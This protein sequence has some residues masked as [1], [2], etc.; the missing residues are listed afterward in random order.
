MEARERLDRFAMLRFG[1]REERRERGMP[2]A[3]GSA[4]HSWRKQ[5]KQRNSP[6]MAR[7][8]STRHIESFGPPAQLAIDSDTI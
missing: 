7:S 3:A 8:S 5:G 6:S 1:L 4:R 2:C